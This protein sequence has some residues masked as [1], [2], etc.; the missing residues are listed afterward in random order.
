MSDR[1]GH[2]PE[3]DDAREN[4]PR[5]G[6]SAID[7]AWCALDR[8]APDEA[9]RILADV[10]RGNGERWTAET[11][12]RIDLRDLSAAER[13]L[14]RAHGILGGEDPG[15]LWATGELR[16][17][18]WQIDR[19]QE[20]YERLGRIERTLPVLERLSLCLEL[21]GD[22]EGADALLAEA[23]RIDP[24]NAPVPPR[25][26]P[27]AFED[28]VRDAV[29]QLPDAFQ[30]AFETMAVIIDPVP[31][32][33]LAAGAEIDTPPDLLGL[34]VGLSMLERSVTDPGDLPPTIYLFQ[35]NIERLCRD[36]EEI[37][38]EIRVTLY[39]ELGHALGLD[40]EGLEEMGLS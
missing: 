3:H 12:A 21:R 35:R 24:E 9:L 26:S 34:F 29:E 10:D 30:E 15:V 19:A 2:D 31:D 4:D 40:E 5:A 36:R 23:A 37:R 17:H 16:L 22:L 8:G 25:L 13:A 33:D 14:R 20:T 28:V 38:E 27:E 32:P 6:I 7:D 11:I 1:S 39:H 18:I